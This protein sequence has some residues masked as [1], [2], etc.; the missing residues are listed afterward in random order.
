MK[1]ELWYEQ[2]A[3]IIYKYILF[4]VKDH[5]AAEDLTQETFIKAFIHSEQFK[6]ISEVKTWLYRIAYTTTMNYFRKKHP[7]TTLLDISIKEKSAEE[8]FFEQEDLDEIFN[9]ISRLKLSYRQVI[10]LRK[11]Q[12]LTI[13]ETSIVINWSES[14][15]K[16]TLNRA[17]K[18]LQVILSEQGGMNVEPL[19]R[20]TIQKVK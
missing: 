4:L 3:E 14:K 5:Q 12:R 18:A 2:Y 7:I 8:S 10:I 17:L 1:V 9:S 15:V 20:Q 19:P 13:K 11:I 16:T 6:G